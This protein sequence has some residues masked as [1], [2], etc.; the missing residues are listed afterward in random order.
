MGLD[1]TRGLNYDLSR[2]LHG[3]DRGLVALPDFQRDFDWTTSD[4]RAL[5]ATVLSGWPIGSLLLMVDP[6]E[7][8]FNL[9]PI[10]Q[11][12]PL[13]EDVETIVL[14]GQQRLTALYHALY[15]RGPIRYGL[16]VDIIDEAQSIDSLD[17]AIVAIPSD[18]WVRK[19]STPFDQVRSNL[20]PMTALRDASEFFEWRDAALSGYPA[21][22]GADLTDIYRSLLGGLHRYDIPAVVIDPDVP[23]A[24][25]ARIFERVNRMGMPLGTFD[26]VVAKSFSPSF[27]LRIEWDSAR[28]D[29]PRLDAFFGDDG[30]GILNVI[31][32]RNSEDVRQK[33]ILEMPGSAAR[34]GWRPAAEA[35]DRAIKFLS[36]RLGVWNPDWLPYKSMLTI[37][38]A[39][40]YDRD[41]SEDSELIQLWFWKAAFERRYDVASNTR[42][43]SDY[44]LLL[45]GSMPPWAQG[46][47]SLIQEDLLECNRKQ[48]G[49]L[50]RAVTCAI[51]SRRPLDAWSGE[52]LD[53]RTIDGGAVPDVTMVSVF[54]RGFDS[55]NSTHLLT[56]AMVL[57]TQANARKIAPYSFNA[58]NRE[59]LTQQLVSDSL[60]D[61][62]AAATFVRGRYELLL[63]HLRETLNTGIRVFTRDT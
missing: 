8:F 23:P 7:R 22:D 59:A 15:G 60:A 4:V 24:G 50:H 44:Q 40:S 31:A 41:L 2:I 12:P 42:A 29:Y 25:I 16:R 56:L 62:M 19:Y 39:L 43:V 47:L 9:R 61:D 58:L 63:E 53:W 20:I 36:S 54:P 14:D 17:E 34:D 27:N 46:A 10:E 37:L 48:L 45:T 49:T 52:M 13:R 18:E 33:A 55:D 3:I 35:M 26:L 6:P 11:A 28:R 57:T 32:L 38:A 51:A 1:K 30:L 5:L 21:Y